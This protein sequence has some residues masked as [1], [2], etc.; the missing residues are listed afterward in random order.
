M[1]FE[2]DT[3]NLRKL[4]RNEKTNFALFYEK[5]LELRQNEEKFKSYQFD[6]SETIVGKNGQ[7][8]KLTKII[9]GNNPSGDL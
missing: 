4:D 1:F 3:E 5:V 7:E 6:V 2:Y 9:G 8:V